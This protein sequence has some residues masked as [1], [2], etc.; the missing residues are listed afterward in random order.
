M[1]TQQELDQVY[2][3][4]AEAHATLSKARRTHV[5]ACLVTKNGVILG[6]VNGTVTG[7]D[8]NCEIENEDGSLTTRPD[9][10]HAELNSILKASKEGV[11]VLDGTMY[12]TL[13]PCSQCAAMLAQAGIK[14]IV[15]RNSY[16]NLD[17]IKLLEDLG[18]LVEKV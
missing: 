5:G 7:A 15:Y 4:V 1:A 6:G 18:V 17:G 3:S 12:I 2:M 10:I 13:S 9:V 14:R 16:R 11:S 8:N